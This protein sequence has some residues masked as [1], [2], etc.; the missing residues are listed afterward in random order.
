MSRAWSRITCGMALLTLLAPPAAGQ[1]YKP[2]EPQMASPTLPVQSLDDLK[3]AIDPETTV[4]VT[5]TD[6]QSVVGTLSDGTTTRIHIQSRDGNLYTFDHA[7]VDRIVEKDSTRDGTIAGAII[8]AIP[9]LVG[10]LIINAICYNEIGSCPGA[11][12][13][14]TALGAGVG[15][16]IGFVADNGRQKLIYD[17]KLASAN[18]TLVFRTTLRWR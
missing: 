6:A 10:G 5:T 11:V 13:G 3:A 16:G 15:A 17:R 12:I 2:V 14:L 4:E 8:G 18:P 1:T 9:G 7:T